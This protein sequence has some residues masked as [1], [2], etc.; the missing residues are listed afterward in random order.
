MTDPT[1]FWIWCFR[2][3]DEGWGNAF[4][5][6]CIEI[7]ASQ[8]LELVGPLCGGSLNLGP[9][10]EAAPKQCPCQCTAD[11]NI[12][13]DHRVDYT[14]YG[15][16]NHTVTGVYNCTKPDGMSEAVTSTHYEWNWP[17]W[18]GSIDA[19]KEG[20][21]EGAYGHYNTDGNTG[22]SI[23]S[24]DGYNAFDPKYSRGAALRT[25]AQNNCTACDR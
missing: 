11:A 17:A 15:V 25:W 8:F 2:P 10:P 7:G 24:R 5:D 22:R 20:H 13:T 6:A 16:A 3:Y 4:F 19:G 12:L 18:D 1:G 14:W 23:W 9:E 21:C